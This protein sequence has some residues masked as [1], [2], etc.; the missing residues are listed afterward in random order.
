MRGPSHTMSSS[1]MP[2]STGRRTGPKPLVGHE[3]ST[4]QMIVLKTFLLIPF[5][6]LVAAIPFAWGWGLTWVDLALAAV[7]YTHRHTR[8]HRRLSPL[9]HARRVQDHQ[10]LTH[11]SRHR[12]QHGR[13]GF[14][15]LLGG[16]P[17]PAPRLR[18]QRGRSAFPVVVRHL[19]VGAAAWFLAR[20]HGLDVQTRGQRTTSGSHPTCC[21]TRTCRSSTVTSGCGSC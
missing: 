4:A 8:R 20:A 18:R 21:P 10:A 9:L 11:R 16:E 14:G 3:R 13:A 12:R 15:A 7:F 6:A 2:T 19:T 1:A 5:V 17:S